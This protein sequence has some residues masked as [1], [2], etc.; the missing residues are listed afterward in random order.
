MIPKR[1]KYWN[2]ICVSL[3]VC[4]VLSF[5]LFEISDCMRLAQVII[6]M[7]IVFTIMYSIFKII[8]NWVY[9]REN[10]KRKQFEKLLYDK[11][12]R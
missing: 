12:L 10:K 5:L 4:E 8:D 6:G 7:P 9:N 3:L 11:H 2:Y 1:V